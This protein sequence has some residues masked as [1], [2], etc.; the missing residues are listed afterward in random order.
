MQVLG[1]ATTQLTTTILQHN[2]KIILIDHGIIGTVIINNGSSTY[3]SSANN[4][5]NGTSLT[6]E[7]QL[8]L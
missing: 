3:V 6:V 1:I 8:V 2:N 7:V 5:A 4:L